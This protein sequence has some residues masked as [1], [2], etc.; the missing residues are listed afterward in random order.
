MVG[1]T[2]AIIGSSK[3]FA[4]CRGVNTHL[5]IMSRN[6]AVERTPQ[7]LP[8]IFQF[9]SLYKLPNEAI[10]KVNPAI[11]KGIFF[12]NDC[13]RIPPLFFYGVAYGSFIYA[14]K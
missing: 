1:A 6:S 12:K 9:A 3:L 2:D 4:A 13:I 5:K 8:A 11:G 10:P 14:A 7:T